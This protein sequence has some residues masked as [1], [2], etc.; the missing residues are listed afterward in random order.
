MDAD[1]IFEDKLQRGMTGYVNKNDSGNRMHIVSDLRHESGR[2]KHAH[3]KENV[4]IMDVL[5]GLLN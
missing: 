3:T 1:G 4:A 2:L 5:V